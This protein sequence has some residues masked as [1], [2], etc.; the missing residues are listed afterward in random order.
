MASQRLKISRL[1]DS[2]IPLSGQQAAAESELSDET[3][4]YLHTSVAPTP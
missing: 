4:D 3:S 1:E 2:E